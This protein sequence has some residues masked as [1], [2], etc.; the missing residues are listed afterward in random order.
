MGPDYS[1]FALLFVIAQA[2]APGATERLAWVNGDHPDQTIEWTREGDGWELT[3]NGREMGIFHRD[4]D[5][6]VHHTG[7]QAPRRFALD[8]LSD[9]VRRDA[10]RVRL[11]GSFAPTVLSIERG[12][13]V[14][15]VD[16]SRRLLGTSLG[17]RSR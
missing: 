17:L 7:G 16:P 14:R 2:L 15:L 8:S 9:P 4:G 10:R 6:V 3:V 13:G 12:G 1:F 11:R 5:A